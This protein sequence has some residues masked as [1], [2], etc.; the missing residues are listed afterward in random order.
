[1]LGGI[2]LAEDPPGQNQYFCNCR[3]F[4]EFD[5]AV[6]SVVPAGGDGVWFLVHAANR[7]EKG[8]CDSGGIS[9]TGLRD[10]EVDGSGNG[11]S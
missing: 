4:E 5:S 8:T 1:M 3:S 9:Q 2:F 10:V 7:K 6:A 11:C